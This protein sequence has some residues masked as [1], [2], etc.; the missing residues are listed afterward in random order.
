AGTV[1]VADINPG[2][3]S[4]SPYLFPGFVNLGKHVFF[5]ASNGTNG[6][7]H[8]VSDGTAAG[9][10]MIAD[11]NPGP[12]SSA[13]TYAAINAGRVIFGAT[14]GPQDIEPF[15]WAPGLASAETFGEGCS[16]SFPTLESTAPA[17]GTTAVLS[18]LGYGANPGILFLNAPVAPKTFMGCNDYI[19][20]A[21]GFFIA[22]VV[23]ANYSYKFL[24]PNDNTLSGIRLHWQ[25]WFVTFPG[26][27]PLQ[28]TNGV[29]WLVGK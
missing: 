2:T 9:T 23:G 25:T 3:L 17:L 18:G 8:W 7:E 10:R 4:S 6:S 24:I 11:L 15:L 28:T 1:M 21:T 14:T 19:D 13:P 20:F 5:S 22:P 27:F 26:I 16:P 12:L 29:E